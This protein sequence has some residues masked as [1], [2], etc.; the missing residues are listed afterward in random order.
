[1]NFVL[2][3]T[4]CYLCTISF[5]SIIIAAYDKYASK[6]KKRRIREITLFTFAF[7]G[8]ALVMYLTMIVIRHKTRH[9]R[10]MLGLPLIIALQI[11]LFLL[12]F[13]CWV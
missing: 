7:I 11:V 4:I 2:I 3:A 12:M 9:R 6:H 5:L 1:M 8:G 10:F 13:R